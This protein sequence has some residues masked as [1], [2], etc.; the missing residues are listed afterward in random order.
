M[1][2]QLDVQP[3]PEAV[4][5][6]GAVF[7]AKRALAEADEVREPGQRNRAVHVLTQIRFRPFDNLL[8]R[9]DGAGT[10]MVDV[11]GGVG[12]HAPHATSEAHSAALLG[13][14]DGLLTKLTGSPGSFPGARIGRIQSI[15]F[16]GSFVWRL[17]QHSIVVRRLLQQTIVVATSPDSRRADGSLTATVVAVL[18]SI[19]LG[20]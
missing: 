20:T 14:T 10:Y 8:P 7:V 9:H 13:L 12:F 5:V 6:A 19:E 11:N 17:P 15:C 3:T 4:A 1:K 2:H 18:G 16:V